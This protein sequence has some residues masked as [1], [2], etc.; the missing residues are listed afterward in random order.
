MAQGKYIGLELSAN[1][2]DFLRINGDL[3]FRGATG[4]LI[5]CVL[6]QERLTLLHRLHY[7]I[8]GVNLDVGLYRRLHR[9]GVFWPEMTNDAKEEQRSCKTCS[10]IPLDQAKVHN[11]ELLEEDWKDPYL[12]Y[13]LQGVL[14]ADREKE[15]N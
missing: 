4:L 12:R 5:K 2:K 3:F 14:L 13:L 7:D 9:L 15:R 1:M 10:I 6:R 8:C 11:G